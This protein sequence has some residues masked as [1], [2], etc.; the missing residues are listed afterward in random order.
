MGF[1]FRKS[2]N[3]GFGSRLNLSKSGIGTSIGIKGARIGAGPKGTRVTGS[4]PGTGLYYTKNINT[5][6][7]SDSQIES[8][9]KQGLK[10]LFII[11]LS[12]GF[13]INLFSNT[14]FNIY[15]VICLGIIYC[16]FQSCLFPDENMEKFDRFEILIEIFSSILIL[17]ISCYMI[18]N[19][20]FYIFLGMFLLNII[21]TIGIYVSN[22]S[23]EN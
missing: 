17:G 12:F 11:L 6:K 22:K 15:L 1:N 7:G 14:A 19:I 20:S 16:I 2:I 10:F 13:L 3:L 23:K 5:K 21:F 18:S 4:V 8:E 9:K